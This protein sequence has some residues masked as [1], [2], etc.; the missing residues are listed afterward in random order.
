ML[1]WAH[2]VRDL[3]PF[4]DPGGSTLYE[5]NEPCPFLAGNHITHR[6]RIDH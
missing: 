6:G 5:L 1:W 2:E 3:V 4:G